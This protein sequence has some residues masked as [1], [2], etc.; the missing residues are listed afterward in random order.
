MSAW[1]VTCSP[2]GLEERSVAQLLLNFYAAQ[3]HTIVLC[4]LQT[5][6][7][8]SRCLVATKILIHSIRALEHTEFLLKDDNRAENRG[9]L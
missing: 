3:V 9:E 8:S 6:V 2:Q 4:E 5:L 7:L 1:L